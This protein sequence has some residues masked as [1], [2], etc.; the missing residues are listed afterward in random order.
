MSK[1]FL[2]ANTGDRKKVYVV[3]AEGSERMPIWLNGLPRGA[4]LAIHSVVTE[5]FG[6]AHFLVDVEGLMNAEGVEGDVT[7]A[8]HTV[9][10][11]A[12]CDSPEKTLKAFTTKV[13]NAQ[14]DDAV[15]DDWRNFD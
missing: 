7:E 2:N 15:L 3:H 4:E 6:S 10:N 9:I 14:I 11:L 5:T 8:G 12:G 1:Y 13:T